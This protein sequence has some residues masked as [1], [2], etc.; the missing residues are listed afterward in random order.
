MLELVNNGSKPA[1]L[2]SLRAGSAYDKIFRHSFGR[3]LFVV[4]IDLGYSFF[5]WVDYFRPVFLNAPLAKVVN[6]FNLD[7]VQQ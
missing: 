7:L 4:K 5:Y 2:V 3:L 6:V 1:E